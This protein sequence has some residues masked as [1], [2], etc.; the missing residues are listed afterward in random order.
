MTFNILFAICS[1][2]ITIL[3]SV[4]AYIGTNIVSKLEKISVA[5]SKIEKDFGILS[6]DH[7]NL[8]EDVCEIKE[9]VKALEN[10]K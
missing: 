9:R 4:V 3:L 2:L 6:N 1:G 10:D 5:L 8:K 7:V